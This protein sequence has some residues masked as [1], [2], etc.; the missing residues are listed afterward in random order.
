MVN[1]NSKRTLH[2]RFL[3][4]VRDR[5]LIYLHENQLSWEYND[6]VNPAVTLRNVGCGL[7]VSRTY[8]YKTFAPLVREGYLNVLKGKPKGQSRTSQYLKLTDK[9][10]KVAEMALS[11][12]YKMQ[13]RIISGKRGLDESI[14]IRNIVKVLESQATRPSKI[15]ILL[16]SI[17]SSGVVDFD[18]IIEK[19]TIKSYSY[20]IL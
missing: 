15:S 8:V 11:R 10:L 13:I 18:E 1:T 3:I 2:S 7:G 19:T 6:E 5:L 9:G 20:Q 17:P 4:P 16:T 12:T 14:Y